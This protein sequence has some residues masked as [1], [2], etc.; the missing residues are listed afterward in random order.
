MCRELLV[1]NA[2]IVSVAP[3]RGGGGVEPGLYWGRE[4][5]PGSFG[6]REG[7]RLHWGEGVLPLE[8]DWGEPDINY[9]VSSEVLTVYDWGETEPQIVCQ[10]LTIYDWGE[11]ER[12]S[13]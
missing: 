11:P 5:G 4:E 9:C 2:K 8:S 1:R 3:L 13:H 10:V 12:A 7:P 6:G